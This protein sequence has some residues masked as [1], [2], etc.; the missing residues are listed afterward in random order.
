MAQATP[1]TLHL[2]E[3]WAVTPDGHPDARGPMAGDEA[4]MT[5]LIA[6]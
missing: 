6:L 5:S 3:E 4:L 2:L 1:D